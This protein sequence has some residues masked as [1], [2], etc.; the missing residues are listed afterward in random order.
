M[1]ILLEWCNRCDGD[2][3]IFPL[4]PVET[5]QQQSVCCPRCQGWGVTIAYR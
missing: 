3:V 1:G 4:I 2:G 5:P